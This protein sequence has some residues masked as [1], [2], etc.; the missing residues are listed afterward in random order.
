MSLKADSSSK[1]WVQF[2]KTLIINSA[3]NHKINTW[4]KYGLNELTFINLKTEDKI[5]YDI[6]DVN[7]DKFM[8]VCKGRVKKGKFLPD[9]P[10]REI[11]ERILINL[12]LLNPKFNENNKPFFTGASKDGKYIVYFSLR[13]ITR[14]CMN[15]KYS[16]NVRSKMVK[17]S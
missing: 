10:S 8:I 2:S 15:N 4:L 9:K 7:I 16:L 3:L 12:K 13:N 1:R 6:Y 17:I 14:F 5:I 11:Q